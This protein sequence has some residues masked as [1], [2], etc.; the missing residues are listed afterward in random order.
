MAAVL[1]TSNTIEP[2]HQEPSW[3]KMT[4]RRRKQEEF[5]NLKYPILLMIANECILDNN[6]AY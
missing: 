6:Q 4:L 2:I 5:F 1:V 3:R